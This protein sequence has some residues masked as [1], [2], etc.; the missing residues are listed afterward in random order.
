MWQ[1]NKPHNFSNITQYDFFFILLSFEW[2]FYKLWLGDLGCY[3]IV[4]LPS[5]TLCFQGFKT[6][7]E[8]AGKICG[9]CCGQDSKDVHYFHPYSACRVSLSCKRATKHRY[10]VCQEGKWSGLVNTWHC[11]NVTVSTL[12]LKLKRTI[13]FLVIANKCRKYR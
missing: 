11:L 10:V 1:K 13:V 12:G 6:G 5:W 9:A 2:L 3:H 4:A 8:R 7:I